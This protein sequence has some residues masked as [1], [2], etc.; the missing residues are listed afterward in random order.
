MIPFVAS[1]TAC[2]GS[3]DAPLPVA[4]VALKEKF[5]APDVVL[6]SATEVAAEAGTNGAPN[7]PAYCDV[8]GTIQG[9]IKFA[10]YMPKDW[11]SRFQMVGNG[12]KAGT[13]QLADMRTAVQAGYASTSTDTGHDNAVPEQAGSRFGNNQLFGDKLEI[14][15]GYRAVHL[16]ATTA[17][18]LV[19]THYARKP[20]Y[21]YWNGCSSGG[22][23]GLQEAQRFPDDFDGYVVGAPNQDYTGQQMSAPAYLQPLYKKITPA[24]PADGP[25]LSP[26]KRVLIGNAIY[27][28]CDG[29][30][31]VV[32]KQ[33]RN[34]LK[35]DFDPGRDVPACTGGA[36]DNC[37]TAA[38][39]SA[40]RQIYAGKEPFV[41]GMPL[42][43]EIVP[44][45]WDTWVLPDQSNRVP[46]LH[47]I[48]VDAFEWLMFDPDRPG[49]D[50]LTQWD[51]SVHPFQMQKAA[52]TY[53]A[54][55]ADL[56]KL[57]DSGKKV[58]MYHGWNDAAVNPVR[59]VRYRQAVID[60]LQANGGDG[61]GRTNGFL[62]LFMVPGM[63]HCSGGTGHS[64]AD[65]LTPAV[66]WV[67]KGVAPTAIVGSRGTSTRPHCPYPQEAVYDGTG[68]KDSASSY[69]CKAVN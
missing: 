65:W 3:D 21:S 12:G 32:D 19:G 51:W 47:S 23:Q 58:V 43:G 63:A 6:T 15:F 38:E 36:T 60:K 26:A 5:D 48:M 29:R 11:N 10:V 27:A 42:G 8:R 67:E 56:R 45:S 52:A 39:L 31:G 64:T 18:D 55:D 35:C 25:V 59:S 69:A 30:D 13:I 2:G 28:R 7:T 22:R 49:F 40:V 14:D 50:Y 61:E 4:C 57:L 34:P 44:G 41:P 66:N 68:D 46:T 33:L 9:N 16:T 54:V 53:N 1:L 24:T 17:K 20:S 37:L 62:R